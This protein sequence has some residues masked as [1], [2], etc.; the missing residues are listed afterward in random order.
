MGN[1]WAFVMD[2]QVLS[3]VVVGVIWSSLISSLDAPTA[4]SS[5]TYRFA[6][7]FLNALAANFAR[8]RS[9]AV[10]ASPNFQDALDKQ[11]KRAG[12]PSIEAVV[13]VPA[14]PIPEE[15]P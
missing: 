9:T 5:P 3:T 15:K 11:T 4:T 14:I 6:F 10:E 8:A 12:Q 7:K 2:H 13:P 1:I